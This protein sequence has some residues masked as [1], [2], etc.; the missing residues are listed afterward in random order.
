M[1][2]V[3]T[4]LWR[5]GA[6]E[7]AETI[8]S[9]RASAREVVEAHPRRIEAVDPAVNAVP[10]VLAE[11]ALDAAA[12][13]DR[14]VASLDQRQPLLG[15]P[16]TVKGNIDVL[17][18]PDVRA[19]WQVMAALMPPDTQRFMS[20]FYAVAG[21]PDPVTTGQ[22]FIVRQALL[23]AWG[24]FQETYPLIVAPIFADISLEAGRDLDDGAVAATI[25]GMRM[26][27]AVNALGLPAVAVPVG[28]ADGLP[29]VVQVIAGRYREHLCLDAAQ[30]IEDRVGLL[31]P[32]D[33]R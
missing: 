20:D 28:V 6:K 12:F 30:A 25:R 31:T 21:E 5:M 22:A 10:V 16:F 29:Q 7:A 24:A 32:I 17:N 26:A 27:M 1:S 2:V 3:A 23:R 18:T 19:G 8:G 11:S 9:R 15:V 13:A 14:L 4:E 33:P